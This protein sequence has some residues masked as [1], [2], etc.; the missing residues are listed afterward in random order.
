MQARSMYKFVVPFLA[1]ALLVLMLSLTP[2]VGLA[3]AKKPINSSFHPAAST[4]A[5]PMPSGAPSGGN[6]CSPSHLIRTQCSIR[7]EITVALGNQDRYG[8]WQEQLPEW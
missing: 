8:F 3:G 4:R 2:S 1:L 7:P 6:G 5:K